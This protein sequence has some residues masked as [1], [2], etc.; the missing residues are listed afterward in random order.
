MLV[1]FASSSGVMAMSAVGGT[2][3]GAVVYCRKLLISAR[4]R[5]ANGRLFGSSLKLEALIPSSIMLEQGEK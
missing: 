3:A 1:R 2:A 5:E 4:E